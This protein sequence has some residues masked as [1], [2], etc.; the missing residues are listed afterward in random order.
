MP[1]LLDDSRV[2]DAVRFSHRSP[3]EIRL[4]EVIASLSYALDLTEG[5]P[6]GHAI[7]SCLIGM[8]IAEDFGLGAERCSA[9]YY[10]LLL[11]DLGCSTN[12]SR[13]CELYGA[14]DLTAKC[15]L[16]TVD[17]TKPTE[18]LRFIAGNV[19]PQGSRWEKI[20]KTIDVALDGPKGAKRMFETRCE[21][22]ADIAALLGFPEETAAA[23]LHLDEHWDG[24]GQ[25]R[26][27]KGEQISLEGRILG[28][29]QTVEVFFG[30]HGL[31]AAL[32]MV[33]RRTGTW[34]DSELADIVRSLRADSAFWEQV[35]GATDR[36]LARK[37]ERYDDAQTA[38]EERLDRVAEGFARVVD[39]KSPWTFR[40]SEGVA[41]AAV[42]IAEV[43]GLP[44]E[45]I[46][47]LRRAGLLHDLGKLG[48][49]NLILDKPG[50]LTDAERLTI[51]LHAGKSERILRRVASFSELADWAWSH[52]ERIDGRG[53]PRGLEGVQ[54]PT[55]VRILVV[56]DI[57]D[58]LSAARPYRAAQPLE[59]VLGILWKDAGST[60]CPVC[61]EALETFLETPAGRRI[62]NTSPPA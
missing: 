43:L 22:G 25:P 47:Q 13:L 26:G 53:Y 38:D 57:F 44:P 34:F 9:L 30:G 35:A 58:A 50:K 62:A 20:R 60:V 19:A 18:T 32:E 15:N 27:L 10:A 39:A 12:A 28:I 14:D 3:T 36:T 4:S 5:Q 23:I 7:R 31:T 46:R 40:H 45:Q 33:E 56:A 1:A 16:K 21:R 51:Q 55:P 59:K 42:G 6:E 29:A 17:W 48:V 54:L 37:Y 41:T 24:R 8:R 11:K 2:H 61:V 49:S 52:H